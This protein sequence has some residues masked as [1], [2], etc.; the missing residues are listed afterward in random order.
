VAVTTA[1]PAAVALK[2]LPLIVAPVVPAFLTLHTIVLFVAFAGATVPVSV[3]GVPAVALAGTPVISVTAVNADET[4]S[5]A[6]FELTLPAEFVTT[7]RYCV[8]LS[9]ACA[10]LMIRLSDLVPS[11]VDVFDILVQVPPTRCCH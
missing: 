7:Q 2:V 6:A 9:A 1:V 4:V 11:M 10:F 8:P 3:S 5:V